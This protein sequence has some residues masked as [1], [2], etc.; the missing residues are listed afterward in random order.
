MS[1]YKRKII[2]LIVLFLTVPVWK[3]YQ[4]KFPIVLSRLSVLKLITKASMSCILYCKFKNVTSMYAINKMVP[5]LFIVS[6]WILKLK[7]IRRKFRKFYINTRK[8]IIFFRL[9]IP[10]LL[11][12]LDIRLLVVSCFYG[13]FDFLLFKV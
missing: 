11:T 6:I 2:L 3:T 10:C 1:Y 8:F 13:D 5:C 7:L 9:K 4:K 12:N